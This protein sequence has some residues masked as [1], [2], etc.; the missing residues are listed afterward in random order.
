M[1]NIILLF[2]VTIS[3]NSIAEKLQD[4]VPTSKTKLEEFTAKTG[5][6]IVRGFEEIGFL[7]GLYGTKITV[8]CKEFTDV[9]SGKVQYGITIEVFKENG[10]YDKDHT[11]FIDYD[12]IQGI[13]EAL[14]YIS[15]I[16]KESTKLKDFQADY[17]TKGDL[18]FSTFSSG[19]KVL[20]AITS[21][22]IGSVTAY[23]KINEIGSIKSLIKQGKDKIDSIR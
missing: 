12:E 23:Y 13:L 4:T 5:A 6:V 9:S 16:T 18:K 10:N 14:D 15:K 21:G 7:K 20:I 19:N 22:N 2:L 11:S 8:E 3:F 1:K 17:A